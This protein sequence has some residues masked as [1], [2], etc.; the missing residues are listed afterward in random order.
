M[1]KMEFD[2]GN[3]AFDDGCGPAEVARILRVAA[4]RID[5]GTKQGVVADVNGN[6]IGTWSVEYAAEGE[7]DED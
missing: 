7:G 2:T 1:F 6:R 4:V 3:A 5:G